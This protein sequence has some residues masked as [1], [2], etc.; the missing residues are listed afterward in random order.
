[1]GAELPPTMLRTKSLRAAL[2]VPAPLAVYFLN[3]STAKADPALEAQLAEY[4]ADEA[5]SGPGKA[6][7]VVS[8]QA[9]DLVY[10][11]YPSIFEGNFANARVAQIAADAL[12][13]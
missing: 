1:M 12:T 11:V 2:L 8:A 10:A 9:N 5:T 13:A 6:T 3:A 4:A 7:T